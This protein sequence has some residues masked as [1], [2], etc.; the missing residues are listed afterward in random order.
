MEN[1]ENVSNRTG[2]EAD[3]RQRSAIPEADCD[4]QRPDARAGHSDAG[5]IPNHGRGI[6]QG[7]ENFGG[8][9]RPTEKAIEIIT[10]GLMQD[11]RTAYMMRQMQRKR[12]SWGLIPISEPGPLIRTYLAVVNA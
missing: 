3:E 7:L 12:C 10:D 5:G 8:E 9:I 2:S 4:M 6:L 11:E 1:L